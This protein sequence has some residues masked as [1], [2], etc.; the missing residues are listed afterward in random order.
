MTSVKSK[1]SHYLPSDSMFKIKALVEA[2]KPNNIIFWFSAV[3]IYL[4]NWSTFGGDDDFLLSLVIDHPNC[5]CAFYIIANT[6][7]SNLSNSELKVPK[8]FRAVVENS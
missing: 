7:L 2:F 1:K 8:A 3:G 6:C 5:N 4:L